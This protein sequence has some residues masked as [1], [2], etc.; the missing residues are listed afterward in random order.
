MSTM[1]TSATPSRVNR[2]RKSKQGP[3]RH[4]VRGLVLSAPR[5]ARAALAAVMGGRP[6][7]VLDD[8][9]S[10]SRASPGLSDGHRSAL[11]EIAA[12]EKEAR[13]TALVSASI[14]S[15][16]RASLGA[17]IAEVIPL[18]QEILPSKL[19]IYLAGVSD[20]EAVTRWK[21]G[22]EGD[23]TPATE[24]RLRAAYEVVRM[25]SSS[26]SPELIRAWF[27]GPDPQLGGASPAGAIREGR[28]Q[29]A[30]AAARLF[31]ISG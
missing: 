27:E 11:L 30:L 31:V 9:R 4:Y 22:K 6:N 7:R 3:L 5:R 26:N 24:Q 23:L 19:I 17:P 21:S 14:V 25:L 29:D 18:L 15:A 13:S 12:S 8:Q 20:G 28:L 2:R 16:R 1:R 10:G